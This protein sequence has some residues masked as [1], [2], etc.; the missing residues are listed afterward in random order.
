MPAWKWKY[1][2]IISPLVFPPFYLCSIVINTILHSLWIWEQLIFFRGDTAEIEWVTQS[3]H[4]FKYSK[5][6]KD[7]TFT[8]ELLFPPW[9][10]TQQQSSWTW[11]SISIVSIKMAND[12]KTNKSHYNFKAYKTNFYLEERHSLH[13]FIPE[14]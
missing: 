2:S 12:T 7:K 4:V 11:L 9:Q 6:N 10:N 1:F 13:T 8:S 5:F 14:G 3:C